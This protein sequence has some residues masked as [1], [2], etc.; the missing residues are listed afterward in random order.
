[1]RIN[2]ISPLDVL[3]GGDRPRRMGA[4]ALR[5]Y[6]PIPPHASAQRAAVDGRL[7]MIGSALGITNERVSAFGGLRCAIGAKFR[8]CPGRS[9]S[10]CQTRTGVFSDGTYRWH[11]SGSAW[12]FLGRSSAVSPLR[13]AIN[14]EFFRWKMRRR[15]GPGNLARAPFVRALL[16]SA[17]SNLVNAEMLAVLRRALNQRDEHPAGHDATQD[18]EKCV[19]GRTEPAASGKRR[20]A[21]EPC[22]RSRAPQRSSVERSPSRSDKSPSSSIAR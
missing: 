15:I 1:M 10:G 20:E 18:A 16:I 11:A 8:G 17:H 21:L 5:S 4:R 13:T 12:Q 19:D 7:A 9:R 2:K 6:A 22:G 3:V 14:N